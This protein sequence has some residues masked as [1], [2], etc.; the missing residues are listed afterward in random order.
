MDSSSGFSH[1]IYPAH[2]L[3]I[4]M[5]NALLLHS[6][7]TSTLHQRLWHL[8]NI[9]LTLPDHQCFIPAKLTLPTPMSNRH[10]LPPPINAH[11]NPNQPLWPHSDST[12]WWSCWLLPVLSCSAFSRLWTMINIWFLICVTLYCHQ[13]FLLISIASLLKAKPT[14]YHNT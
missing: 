11:D 10:L 6:A 9:H 4:N 5:V 7:N 14:S 3:Q 2:I 13:D 12:L 8:P 1:S